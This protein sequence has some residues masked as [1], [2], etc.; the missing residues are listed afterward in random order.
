MAWGSNSAMTKALKA[1]SVRLYGEEVGILEERGGKMRFRYLPDAKQGLSLSLP[2]QEGYFTEKKCKAYFG[3]LL[4]ESETT[5]RTLARLYKINAYNDFALL[6]AIGRDCAGAVSF[7]PPDEAVQLSIEFDVKRGIDPLT[8]DELEAHLLSLPEKPLSLGRR[9][10]LAGA[11]E[12]TAI[13]FIEG[14]IGLPKRGYPTTHIIKPAIRGYKES[15]ANEYI[16]MEAAQAMGLSVPQVEMRRVKDVDFFMIE[17]FD[18]HVEG[19]HVSRLQQEDFTQAL[20]I[21]A[22]DKYSVTFKQCVQVLDQLSKPAINKAAFV[23]MVVFNTLI[24]NCDA[25]GKNFSIL[26]MANGEKA[27]TP[28]YDIVCTCVYE[29][30]DKTMAM[31]I[32]RSMEISHVSRADWGSF[33]KQIG[34]SVGLVEATV[35]DQAS[36]LPQAV[37]RI[38]QRVGSSVGDDILA[39]VSKQCMNT[40]E[41]LDK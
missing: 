29:G 7:H 27:L 30:L 14:R 4:P 12:K 15:V 21:W 40:L 32:G 33:A 41:R 26:Y 25:H 39:F 28:V 23:E 5:R 22:E 18:R 17:R 34:V 10:S 31:K 2:L 6:A 35:K 3:G 19:S 37:E 11:Q 13:V 36:R 38:V 8:E 20:G 24:G 9:L 1:L 16:C